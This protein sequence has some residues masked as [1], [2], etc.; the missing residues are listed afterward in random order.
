[1]KK[2]LS[3]IA[4]SISF[5]SW[6]QITITE[7]DFPSGGDTALVTIS[8]DTSI[9]LVLTGANTNWDFS[10]I[11]ID[12]QRID[13]FF[14]ISE[15][16]AFYQFVFN[17]QF[18]NPDY[19]SEYFTAWNNAV[20]FSQASALGLE[21]E[22]PVNFTKISSSAIEQVGFGMKINGISV[23]AASDTI[24]VE[25]QLPF[26]YSDSWISNSYTNL[27]LNPQFNGI[28]RRYQQRNSIVDGWGQITTPFKTY[29]VVRVKSL[30]NAQDSV[31]LDLGF[32]G[33]WIELPTPD[34]IEYNWIAT[35][36]KISV[37]KVVTQDIAGNETIT[38]VEFKDK[39]RDFVSITKFD[40]EIGVY[41]NPAANNVTVSTEYTPTEIQIID[42]SGKIV[43][44]NMPLSKQ[45]V[46]DVSE[47][48]TGLYLIKIFSENKVETVKLQV[49]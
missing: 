6:T 39:K 33:M 9:D 22:N 21:I 20:D 42:L 25:Y 17:N 45:S 13:T 29:D 30:I 7:T 1:M 23:P 28:Y 37:F 35:G 43:Q 38:T 10:M 47:L 2:F 8:N 36:E 14:D 19:A 16:E 4:L 27:D 49:Q 32:G 31:Y 40:N 5:C 41:P 12:N 34:Q 3:I 18:T 44:S 11:S 15:A 46:L 26:T 48:N 24:D